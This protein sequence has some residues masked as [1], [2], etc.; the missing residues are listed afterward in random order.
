ML[1]NMQTKNLLML[2]IKLSAKV[3]RTEQE[4]FLFCS[5]LKELHLRGLYD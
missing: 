3:K 1:D 4:E 2:Y 5:V